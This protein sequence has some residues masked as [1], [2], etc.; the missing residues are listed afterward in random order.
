[1]ARKDALCLSAT[2]DIE[3]CRLLK[4]EYKMFHFTE[5]ITAEGEVV[6]NY[7]LR[8]GQATTRIAIK[9]LDSLGFDKALIKSANQQAEHYEESGKW[10]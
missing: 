1:M 9:L 4:E 7:E 5:Q 6:F 3:L 10:S 8:K 2:H